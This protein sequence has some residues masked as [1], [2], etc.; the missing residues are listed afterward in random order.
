MSS[1]TRRIGLAV[2]AAFCCTAAPAQAEP[3]FNTTL[4]AS[5]TNYAWEGNPG[6]GFNKTELLEYTP[7]GSPNHDCEDVLVKLESAG[8][9]TAEIAA[10]SEPSDEEDPG[11]VADLDLF[12]FES[13]AAGEPGKNLASTNSTSAQEKI[14]KKGLLPG[15]YLVRIDYYRG[16]NL[17]YSG[18][19]NLI[20]AESAAAP[21]PPAT[22]TPPAVAPT[23][24]AT[25]PAPSSNAN[26]K[27]KQA[28]C[29]KK[30]KKIKNAKKRKKALKRCSKKR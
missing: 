23:P 10:P 1:R 29:K 6:N 16:V 27:K 11:N 5:T 26:A 22:T 8:Q 17:S 4:S 30:A 14:T 21:A 28:A 18:K 9:L 2:V 12:L 3:A 13:N 15:F 25:K 20:P 19:L 7:C 24:P